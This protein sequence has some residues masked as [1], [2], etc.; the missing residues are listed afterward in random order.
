MKQRQIREIDVYSGSGNNWMLES[1]DG[2]TGEFNF[3]QINISIIRF[4]QMKQN[5]KKI[6]LET[7]KLVIRFQKQRFMNIQV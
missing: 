2:S 6:L 7:D 3:S 4:Y 5:R 1:F